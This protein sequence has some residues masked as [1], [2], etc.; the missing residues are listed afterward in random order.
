[1]TL[2]FPVVGG[3]GGVGV[4]VCCESVGVSGLAGNV[5]GGSIVCT[6]VEG[7]DGGGG[8]ACVAGFSAGSG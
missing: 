4:F 6:D 5:G 8:G 7:N 1:M 2:T 3:V